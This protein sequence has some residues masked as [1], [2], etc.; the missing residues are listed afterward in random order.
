MRPIIDRLPDGS[1]AAFQAIGYTIGGMM[2]FPGNQ[3]GR[4]PTINVARGFHR[5]ISDRIDL[6]LECIRRHYVGDAPNPLG[7]TLDRYRDFFALFGDFAGYVDFF[8]LEDLVAEDGAVRFLLPFD[9][10]RTPARPEDLDGYLE[11][12]RRSMEFLASR[13]ARIDAWARTHLLP[14]DQPT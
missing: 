5:S 6:I 7:A 9:D 4:R 13:N 11:Y 3:I 8:L 2:V 12:R 1:S 14:S 10:F